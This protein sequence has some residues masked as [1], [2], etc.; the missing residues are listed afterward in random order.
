MIAINTKNESFIFIR[1]HALRD[2]DC[3]IFH[4][5]SRSAEVV[6][7][8]NAAAASSATEELD[9]LM[10]SLSTFKVDSAHFRFLFLQFFF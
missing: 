10:A 3:V 8:H 5:F 2:F 7:R 1:Y 4:F 6:G 9:V